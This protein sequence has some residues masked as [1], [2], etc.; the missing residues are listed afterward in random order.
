[1]LKALESCGKVYA[2]VSN[3]ASVDL[4]REESP[5][6]T[7]SELPRLTR[8]KNRY[9]SFFSSLFCRSGEVIEKLELLLREVRMDIVF[10][11]QGFLGQYIAYF[12]KRGLP[13]IYSTANA[14]SEL[15]LQSPTSSPFKTLRKYVIALFQKMHERT[16]FTKADILICVSK[17]DA[18]FHSRF[19]DPGK[20]R[21]IPNYIDIS[22]YKRSKIKEDY[23]V[24]SG[25]FNAFQ[26]VNGLKW[27]VDRVWN[28]YKLYNK[29][30][31]LL[32]GRYSDSILSQIDVVGNSISGT[33]AVKDVSQ[34]V[35]KARLSIVPLLHGSGTRLK[36][37]EAMA[38]NSPVVSTA[39][40]AE[41]IEHENAI[42]IGDTPELFYKHICSLLDDASYAKKQSEKA[43]SVLRQ[44]Y[45][46]DVNTQKLRHVIK[47]LLPK[48]N[49]E[50][51]L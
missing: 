48:Q 45:A 26:N 27:F 10:I 36:I 47:G 31:L 28:P 9:L 25:A 15:T 5:R 24:M 23:I 29:T 18:A 8:A 33:G 42:L 34:Y 50:R 46:L 4:S 40:G 14:Q 16:F 13:V 20:I 2:F 6:L 30:R 32:V 43:Y 21:I 38:L 37:L 22:R 11:D 44:K 41:G 19:I 12:T 39:L 17:E 3:E 1:M 35:S 49:K 51:L 7:L